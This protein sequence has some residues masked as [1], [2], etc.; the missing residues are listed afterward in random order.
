[1]NKKANEYS[2]MRSGGAEGSGGGSLRNLRTFSSLKD[3]VFRLYFGA[4]LGHWISLSMQMVVRSLLIYRITGSGAI[5]GSMALANAIPML[6][7]SLF[8]GVIADRMPK[9]NIL[10]IGLMGSA[11]IA[12]GIALALTVGYLGPERPGSWWL[13]IVSAVFQ[14]AI[15]GFMMPSV[16]AI[17]PEMVSEDRVMNAVALNNL[18][19]NTFRLLAPALTG[20]LVDA[21]DFDVVYYVSTAM[22]VISVFSI[23][24]IP[25][26]RAMT[27][28]TSST[29]TEIGKGL[30]YIRQEASIFLILVF[31]LICTVFGMPF[32]QLLP[33][34]TEDILKVGATGLGV[35]MSVSGAGS[36]VVSL[37]IASM[38][39]RKRG[40]MLILGGLVVSLALVGFSFSQWWYPSLVLI[41]FV[42]LG[43]T[44]QLALGVVLIQ[45]YVDASY[46]GRVLS[47]HFMGVGFASLGAFLGGI[48]AEAVGVSW[49]DGHGRR[50]HVRDSVAIY[51]QATETGLSTSELTLSHKRSRISLF[52]TFVKE[53][54]YCIRNS[55]WTTGCA[56]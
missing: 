30:Q 38:P 17:I 22:Y 18:G 19:G 28:S 15:M 5:L 14:G 1:M 20:F 42:G 36:L 4:M 11:V 31:S 32:T 51:S 50:S 49:R 52:T 9:K 16:N 34:F 40:L 56:W 33:M 24:F 6:V 54:R 10:L 44:G 43:N 35:L 46:R 47:F 2:G 12:L 21:F 45:S 26:T 53:V 29:L 37:A 23:A 41:F 13:L 39:N 8:G 7:L 55:L 48:L 25:R 3:S 27:V